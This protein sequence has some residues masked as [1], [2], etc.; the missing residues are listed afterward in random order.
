MPR[1]T[2]IYT[3]TGDDGMTSLGSRRRAPKDDLRVHAYGE[4]DEL[5]SLLGLAL[6][7]QLSQF[8]M[9]I[10]PRIQNDLFDLGADLAFP[11]EERENLQTPDIKESHIEN[12]EKLID[13]MLKVVG[14]LENFI[15]PGGSIGAAYLHVARTVCRRA[16]RSVVSLSRLEEIGE[17]VIR[18]LNRLSDLLF[19]M[20]R[21]E[22]FVQGI[23]ESLWETNV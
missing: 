14:P 6:T 21:Y 5:N 15:L 22:N 3:R 12:L 2:K 9:D 10:L 8:S 19:T 1:L 18:Y 4:V 20:A 13:E 7:S 11:I 17:Y 23:K 16:E